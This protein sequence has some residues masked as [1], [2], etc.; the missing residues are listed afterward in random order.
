MRGWAV[1]AEECVGFFE[2]R[3]FGDLRTEARKLLIVIYEWF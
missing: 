1:P 3:S 2:G